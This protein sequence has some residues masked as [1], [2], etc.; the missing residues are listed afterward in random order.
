MA[1]RVEL[2]KDLVVELYVLR[3]VRPGMLAIA[4]PLA[5][6]YWGRLLRLPRYACL[7]LHAS[8]S[9]AESQCIER[10]FE[11]LRLFPG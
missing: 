1:R 5:V 11:L 10:V 6:R 4:C 2:G 3:P 7:T 8:E 9:L